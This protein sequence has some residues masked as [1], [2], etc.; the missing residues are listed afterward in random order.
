M[1][2]IACRSVSFRYSRCCIAPLQA[3][4][5]TVVSVR[6]IRVVDVMGVDR[7]MLGSDAPFPLGEQQVGALVRGASFLS[8]ADRERI[9]QRNAEEFFGLGGAPGI[10]VEPAGAAGHTL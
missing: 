2:A 1:G 8:A 3:P 6:S 7:V 5:G 4:I 9:L 10:G